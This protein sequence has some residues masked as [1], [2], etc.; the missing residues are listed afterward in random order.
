M[1][2]VITQYLAPP[3]N[4]AKLR[5]ALW[6]IKRFKTEDINRLKADDWHELGRAV[7]TGFILDCAEMNARSALERKETRWGEMGGHCRS[8][9]P[10]RDD[11]NWLKHVLVRIDPETGEM[12]V[13]TS[14]VKRTITAGE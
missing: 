5:T 9:F 4:E 11:E 1:R 6:W 7:E 8:D 10:E 14:P 3:R 2:R 12:T 13:L